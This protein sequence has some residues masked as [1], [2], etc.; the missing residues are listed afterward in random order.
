LTSQLQPA[1]ERETVLDERVEYLEQQLLSTAQHLELTREQLDAATQ[2]L[3]WTRHRMADWLAVAY[4]RFRRFNPLRLFAGSQR[5]NR[6]DE[7][8]TQTVRVLREARAESVPLA[9]R[10][11]QR[12]PQRRSPASEAASDQGGR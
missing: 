12:S 3:Q 1:L 5:S 4:H 6:T 11:E 2:R 8:W 9:P 7:Q 10:V